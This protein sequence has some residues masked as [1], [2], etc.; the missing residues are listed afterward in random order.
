MQLNIFFRR[1]SKRRDIVIS[2]NLSNELVRDRTNDLRSVVF[3]AHN[4]SG[5]GTQR[6]PLQ[7][8]LDTVK[9]ILSALG[10]TNVL[11]TDGDTLGENSSFHTLVDDNAESTLGNIEHASGLAVVGLVGHTLLEGTA[12]LNV[13]NVTPLVDL[14]VGGQMF[15]SLLLVGTR[16]HVSRTTTKSLRIGHL[17][18]CR[19][20]SSNIG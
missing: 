2:L 10:V 20:E 4:V 6:L 5:S 15:H 11:N 14:Q 8:D 16:E 1:F 9:E 17:F 18:S 13:N 7:V 3:G 19:S 12:T